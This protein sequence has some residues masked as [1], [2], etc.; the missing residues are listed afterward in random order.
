MARWYSA[1]PNA[2]RPRSKASRAAAGC[3]TGPVG[4][5]AISA[6]A[7]AARVANVI[8]VRTRPQLHE[9]LEALA[10]AD[11]DA[12]GRERVA[13]VGGD[14]DLLDGIVVGEERDVD[15]LARAR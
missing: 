2:V 7:N 8:L 10:R 9:V 14:L 6:P 1:R 3:G 12:L 11:A 4:P 13:V 5:T 15:L